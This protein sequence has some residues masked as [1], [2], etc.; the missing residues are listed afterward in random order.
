MQDSIVQQIKERLDIVE[1]VGSY[2]KL[3]KT[4]VNYRALC[5]FHSEK[6]P[7]FF[8]SPS[9]QS[10]RCFGCGKGGSVFDFVME[11]E[12]IDFGDA[13]RILAQRAGVELKKIEPRLKTE[14]THLYEIC[15]LSCRFFQKQLEE[16]VSGKKAKEY[17]LKR[18]ISEESIKKWRLGYAP[19]SWRA[20]S[21]FLLN[22]GYKRGEIVKAGLAVESEKR[23]APYDRF[24]GRI[25]FPV[26]DLNSQVIGFGARILEKG[27]KEEEI[28]KYINTPN[29]LLYDK[30]R[31]LY[32][33]NFAKM[34][35]RRNDSVILMEGYTDVILAHQAGFENTVAASGTSLTSFQLKILKRYTS[36]LL[37]SFDMDTAG[38]LATQKGIDLAQKEDFDIKVI[39][40]PKDSD[41]ADII[42]K[43]P[44]KWKELVGKAEDI[45]SFYFESAF[46]KFDKETP[47]GKKEI[48]KFLLPKIKGIPNKILQAHWIQ[49]LS[50]AI[51]VTEEA[52]FEE[53][54]KVVTKKEEEP[55]S[56]ESSD[57]SLIL[58]T[59]E[60]SRKDILEERVLTLVLKDPSNLELIEEGKLS[61]F[62]P[63]LKI[64]LTALK[65]EEKFLSSAE[66]EKVK[67]KIGKILEKIK[68]GEQDLKN[69]LEK[70][71]LFAE[72]E[73]YGLEASEIKNKKE[74][75]ELCLE[76]LRKIALKDKLETLSKEIIEAEKEG[77]QEKVKSLIEQ[78]NETA[79]QLN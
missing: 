20:L 57:S 4:G 6:K 39:S 41:P 58:S 23:Q 5:P 24:R 28:A 76:E 26:F 74:E 50:K 70:A 52:V 9:R 33:L 17:L 51:K 10:W 8:V 38:N 13:L 43:D 3:Q 79:R 14:R 56:E 2:L 75:L 73:D 1:V 27:N 45:F 67:E 44:K 42:S 49:E 16:S 30:S 53:L 37:I 55:M 21:D 60:K 64:I 36:N 11:I 71:T 46:S 48:A 69:F 31:T 29:T 32:G 18:G 22:K 15:D 47:S 25:I 77:N 72:V 34:A 65:K 40:L 61:L 7:S 78:F 19:D 12:G 63:Q 54:K 68:K 35:V 59:Q 66:A 62:S